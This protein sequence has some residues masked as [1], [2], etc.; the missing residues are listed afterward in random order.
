MTILRSDLTNEEWSFLLEHKIHWE[1]LYDARGISPTGWDKEAK[2]LGLDFGLSEP[3]YQG[4]RLRERKGHCIQCKTSHIAFIRRSAAIGYV[5]IAVSRKAKLYK[6]GSTIDH[7]QRMKALQREGY[8]GF[9]D[10][11]IICVCRVKN[12][13]KVEFE[14]HKKLDAFK[15]HS[16]YQNAGVATTAKEAFKT[17]LITVWQAYQT[18]VDWRN[19][20]DKSKKRVEKFERFNFKH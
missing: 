10:W 3:C 18:T 15:V 9:D 7:K 13:G 5:Y 2:S 20:P 4:H 11:A 6:I 17:D 8:A 14:I 12:S 16:S 1:N 19:L